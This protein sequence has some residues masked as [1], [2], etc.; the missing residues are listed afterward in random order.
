[1]TVTLAMLMKDPPLD[2]LA[3]LLAYV[4]PVVSEVVAVIDDRTSFVSTEIVRGM[5]VETV[6]FSWC[7]DFAAARN[8]ALPHC[9]GDWILH[10]D[11]DELPTRD[12]LTFIETVDRSG[13]GDV[14]WQGATYPAPRG[15]LVFTRNWFDG[16]QAAE[17][18]E[19]WHCRLFRRERG[20]W[21]RPVHELVALDNFPEAVTRGTPAL[22]KAP[23]AAY[24]IHSR[25]NVAAIDEQYAAIAGAAA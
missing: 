11:P 17:W 9:T 4:R 7:D 8:A 18:E 1:M 14:E 20:Q 22:P 10:L 23:R 12:L 24:L 15:Y 6:P 13:W 16:V 2:R 19:H 5:G 25:M 3:M 21:Y